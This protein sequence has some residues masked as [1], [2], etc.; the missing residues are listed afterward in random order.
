MSIKIIADNRKAFYEYHILS[1]YE[2]GIALVGSEVKSAS[3]GELSLKDSYC[4]VENNEIFL[5]NTYIKP[6]EK[7]SHFNTEPRR[8][9]KLLLHKHEISKISGK[10]RDSGITIVPL[11]AYFKAGHIKIEIALVKGK[12]LHDKKQAI[13]EKDI[14][15]SAM[16]DIKSIK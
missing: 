16:R 5:K 4:R 13:K 11:K 14:L 2:A 10:L 7:G 9:R 1:S 15:K 3:N 12:K 6:Y 8:D